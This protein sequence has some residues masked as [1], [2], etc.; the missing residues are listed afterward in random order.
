MIPEDKVHFNPRFTQFQYFM[1]KRD[2]YF[3]NDIFVLEIE[4][5]KDTINYQRPAGFLHILKKL[6]Q[7]ILAPYLGF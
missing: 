6:E 7:D 4:N 3:W 2:E 5:L 1:I